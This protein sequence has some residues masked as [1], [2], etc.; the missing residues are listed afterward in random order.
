MISNLIAVIFFL[1]P[2]VFAEAETKFDLNSKSL[3]CA[4]LFKVVSDQE[5]EL[6][7]VRNKLLESEAYEILATLEDILAKFYNEASTLP[8]LDRSELHQQRLERIYQKIQGFRRYLE[9]QSRLQTSRAR[10]VEGHRILDFYPDIR[11]VFS[12]LSGDLNSD[13]NKI[14]PALP[15]S[16]AKEDSSRQQDVGANYSGG[17]AAAPLTAEITR[18]VVPATSSNTAI[19]EYARLHSPLVFRLSPEEL[20][21]LISPIETL[22]ESEPSEDAAPVEA[23]PANPIVDEREPGEAVDEQPAI[24][25]P[26]E[27][28]EEL[29]PAVSPAEAAQEQPAKVSPVQAVQELA[30]LNFPASSASTPR[31]NVPPVVR[32][33]VVPLL[34]PIPRRT[35]V[36]YAAYEPLPEVPQVILRR[37]WGEA[38]RN[39]AVVRSHRNL[40][41]IN[42]FKMDFVPALDLTKPI[43]KL[44][45]AMLAM[46]SVAVH[47]WTLKVVERTK[48]LA[49]L[50]KDFADEVENELAASEIHAPAR[51]KWAATVEGFNQQFFHLAKDQ[52]A[53]LDF[54]DVKLQLLDPETETKNSPWLQE[55]RNGIVREDVANQTFTYAV[56]TDIEATRAIKLWSQEELSAE[57]LFRELDRGFRLH[58]RENSSRSTLTVLNS[59]NV[60]QAVVG[61]PV[62]KLD[63]D[64]KFSGVELKG[65]WDPASSRFFVVDVT[66]PTDRTNRA[67]ESTARQIRRI[68]AACLAAKFGL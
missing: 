66:D 43:L 63:L 37:G 60:G 13:G 65:C 32:R 46:E 44:G 45:T 34:E 49:R 58:G 23:E 42:V 59:S 31:T 29:P 33:L 56:S 28:V 30:N 4:S 5:L 24:V 36:Q 26:V 64:T 67:V 53:Q 39:S 9:N 2:S 27:A 61:I 35:R 68:Q 51:V 17:A 3:V 57:D 7:D 47:L 11:T 38:S 12:A 25:S 18:V 40:P 10:W 15:D 55:F 14:V 20:L 1:S 50:W 19:E 16:S 6:P 21:N 41:L 62:Y 22:V 54:N 52:V 48:H 8:D